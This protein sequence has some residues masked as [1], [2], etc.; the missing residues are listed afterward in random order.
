MRCF[1]VQAAFS[2]LGRCFF[3]CY[4][5]PLSIKKRIMCFSSVKFKCKGL[6]GSCSCLVLCLV[7][8]SAVCFTFLH[9][10]CFRFVNIVCFRFVNTV[11][12][13]F[14]PKATGPRDS[15]CHLLL[16]KTALRNYGYSRSPHSTSFL[17]FLPHAILHHAGIFFG[18]SSHAC[19]FCFG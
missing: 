12:F 2:F 6:A 8:L 14:G 3:A 11:C 13:R 7:L 18:F 5:V 1:E 17:S 10:L 16:L 4:R 9:A 19:H 15:D